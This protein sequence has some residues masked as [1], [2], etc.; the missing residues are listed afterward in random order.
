MSSRFKKLVIALCLIIP[1]SCIFAQI[2]NIEDRRGTF[3]DTTGWYENLNIGIGLVKNK[4]SIVSLNG[5]FQIEVLNKKRI[6]L[7]ISRFAFV[8]AGGENFVNQ[9]FQHLRFNRLVSKHIDFE[10]FGQ[11]QYNTLVYINLRALA[12]GGLKFRLLNR[13]K[14]KLNIG[15][16]VMYEY[17]EEGENNTPRNDIRVSNYLSLAIRLVDNARFSCTAY[18]QPLYNKLE[19]YRLSVDSML[20]FK[21]FSS[22]DFITSFDLNYDPRVPDNFPTTIYSLS[23]GISYS[24]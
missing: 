5:A 18:F 8:K 6:F 12:G 16:A 11:V 13:P 24:F 1:G 15:V 22:V 2:V 4:Q 19:D 20:R 17:D 7:S 21:F 9:G 3:S 14:Q 10:T 23:N